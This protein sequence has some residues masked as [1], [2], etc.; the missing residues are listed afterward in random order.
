MSEPHF[1]AQTYQLLA[2]LLIN[3]PDAVLLHALA[4]LQIEEMKTALNQ[5]W[6]NLSHASKSAD[7]AQL[8]KEFQQLFL[9]LG[10]GEVLPFASY[11]LSGFLMEKPLADLRQDLNALGFRRQ[12][13]NKEPEDHVSAICEV[14]AFLVLDGHAAQTDFFRRHIASW[15]DKFFSDLQQAP[16]AAFYLPVATLGSEFISFE[17]AYLLDAG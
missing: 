13:A 17:R 9:G 5:A 1:R 3:P 7:E 4:N 11:Y 16:S 2:R 12:D 15:F 10:R 14:M 8:K 6:L